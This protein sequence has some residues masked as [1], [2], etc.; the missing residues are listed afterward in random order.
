MYCILA[1]V[2]TSG[3]AEDL[4]Y[5]VTVDFKEVAGSAGILMYCS[6]VNMY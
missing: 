3:L 1:A 4:V 6:Y 5:I 2:A